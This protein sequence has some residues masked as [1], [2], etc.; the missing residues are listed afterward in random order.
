M[1]FL[2]LA[3]ISFSA[4]LR[5][6]LRSALTLLGIVIGILSVSAI[7]SVVRGI[8]IYMAE[9][10]GSIGSQGFVVTKV[11]LAGGEEEYLKA[12]RRK[13]IPATAAEVIKAECPS[14][15]N[16]APFVRSIAEVKTARLSADRVYIE[17]TNTDAQ[18]TS[19]IGLDEGRYF[20]PYEI[21]HARQV[22]IVGAD[23]AEKIF[24]SAGI[25]GQDVHIGGRR[26]RVIG[27]NGRLGTVF[28]MSQDSFVRIPYS[29]FEKI[30]G[31]GYSADISVRCRSQE[32]V[33]QAVQEV[34]AVM[35]RLRKLDLK[36]ED[37]FGILTSEALMRLWRDLSSTI[38]LATIG[39]GSIALF[40][41][42]IGIMNIMFVSVKERTGEIG[43]RKAIGAKRRDILLQFLTESSL[44]CLVGGGIG[45]GIG[46]VSGLLLSWKTSIPVSTGWSSIS[47][48]LVVSIGVGLF[49]GV[50]PAVKASSLPP[51]DAL[52]DMK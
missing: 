8:D 18:Y 23:V 19:D 13:N 12:L 39:V 48:A 44:L 11:G 35:R 29:A 2:D 27:T 30:F 52:R 36:E 32:D 46:I 4:L 42:G 6:K 16:A 40:V 20:T 31:R 9:L 5:H 10:L 33:P 1:T 24:T 22:C 25:V 14:V 3:G 49:F 21:Q 38:F 7:T 41:G 28:G 51:A 43:L 26:F 45:V 15:T 50:Y 17:G 47:I 37:D 34:R